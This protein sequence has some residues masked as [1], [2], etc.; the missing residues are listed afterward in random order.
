M[1]DNT[2]TVFVIDTETTGL[3]PA[4]DRI[5]EIAMVPLD[6]SNPAS[7]VL[8]GKA[9]QTLVNPE[10]P[11]P[12]EAAATHHI[13][14]TMVAGAPPWTEI[15]A[16]VDAHD[17]HRA[18][19]AHH[20]AFDHAF[21]GGADDWICTQRLAKHVY[22]LAPRFSNQVLRYWLGL[23]GPTV[24]NRDDAVRYLP[25]RALGDAIVTAQLLAN[26]IKR[27][28][29]A[30]PIAWARELTRT[31]VLL[32]RVSF[33]KHQGKPWRDVPRDYL[34]WALQQQW[35][36][37]DIPYTIAYALNRKSLAVNQMPSPLPQTNPTGAPHPRGAPV[38]RAP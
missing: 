1:H 34:K 37:P 11:I 30:D 19:A 16:L 33:G 15:K 12:P 27:A 22:P 31:P 21:V 8:T 10:R 38:R 4:T 7:P 23:P 3:D 35:D 26:L 20:A 36:D 2:K 32:H 14:D 6:V 29:P 9:F 28:R 25:H 13:T 18:F 5:V 24:H 17:G